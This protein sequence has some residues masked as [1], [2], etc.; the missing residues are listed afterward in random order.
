MT[1][2]KEAIAMRIRGLRERRAVLEAK[3]ATLDAE[4]DDIVSQ[5]DGLTEVQAGKINALQAR[6]V[7]KVED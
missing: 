7:V 5:R 1:T 4:I 2:A 3:L 6:G